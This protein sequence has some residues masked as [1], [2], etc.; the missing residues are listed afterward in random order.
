MLQV[1]PGDSRSYDY[2]SRDG[3]EGSAFMECEKKSNATLRPNAFLLTVRFIPNVTKM[4]SG[5]SFPT[6]CK[7]TQ[8]RIRFKPIASK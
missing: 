8:K 2:G 4:D 6:S 1:T 7:P 5:I 3:F